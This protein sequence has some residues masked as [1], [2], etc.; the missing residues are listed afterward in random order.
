MSNPDF[1]RSNPLADPEFPGQTE[2]PASPST[3]APTSAST[4]HFFTETTE[5]ITAPTDQPMTSTPSS[6]SAKASEAA[7][8]LAQEGQQA[9]SEVL[10]TAKNEA[11]R[12]AE[13]AKDQ[14]SHLLDELG[15]DL[16]EQASVQQQKVA[17][18]LRDISEEFRS[19]LDGSQA[20]GTAAT[21]VDQ[22]SH[23]SGN[24][25]DWLDQREPGDLVDEVKQFARKRPGAFLGLALGAGLLAGRITRNASSTSKQRDEPDPTRS[26]PAPV[27]GSMPAQSPEPMLLSHPLTTDPSAASPLGPQETVEIN[28]LQ[29]RPSQDPRG[30]DYK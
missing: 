7:K 3:P 13:Q 15:A 6:D 1:P 23:H 27:D 22:A 30:D 26:T 4:D 2:T 25:A 14:A 21:L 9:A 10:D 16:R 8:D 19:M 28:P 11:S 5:P 12:V 18:N 29:S 20:S 24:I 17:A